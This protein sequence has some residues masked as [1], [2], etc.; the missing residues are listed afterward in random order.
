LA[1]R[2]PA[3][4]LSRLY[5]TSHS[6]RLTSPTWSSKCAS[7]YTPRGSPTSLLRSGFF[8][9]SVAPSTMVFFFGLLQL[10]SWLSTLTLIGLA[11]PT[12]VSPSCGCVAFLDVSLVSWSSKQQPVVS[13]SSAEAEYR[14]VAYGMDGASWLRRLLQELHSP[15]TPCDNASAIYLPINPVQH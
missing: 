9:I 8:A 15:L 10:L 2:C 3:E 6:P 12:H 13:H 11:A 14:V 5:S 7:T 4:A 1:T